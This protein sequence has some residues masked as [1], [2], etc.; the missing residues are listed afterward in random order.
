MVFA[1]CRGSIHVDLLHNYSVHA[2]AGQPSDFTDIELCPRGDRGCFPLRC[3]DLAS[4]R[5][6]MCVCAIFPCAVSVVQWSLFVLGF[7]GPIQQIRGTFCWKFVLLW[8][9]TMVTHDSAEELGIDTN[10]PDEFERVER[11]GV[12]DK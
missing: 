5:S 4:E 1:H 7:T 3:C 11:K 6:Q 2:T 12:V 9:L 10:G 8:R